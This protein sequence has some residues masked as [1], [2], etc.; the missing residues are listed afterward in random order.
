MTCDA[1]RTAVRNTLAR[2]RAQALL[3]SDPV[4]VRYLTGFESSNAFLLIATEGAA[5]FTDFRYRDAAEE[6]ARRQGLETVIITKGLARAVAGWCRAHGIR[7]AAFEDHHLTVASFRLLRTK[8]RGIAWLPAAVPV[9][10]IRAVKDAAE[11]RAI[12]RA[13]T[14]AEDAFR[15]IP[16]RAWVGLTELEAAEMLEERMRAA[17]RRHGWHADRAFSSIVAAGANASMPHHTPSAA[18]IRAGTLLKID[19]GARVD[20]YCSDITRT[21][22]LGRPD[23]RFKSIYATVLE[24]Q[25]AAIKAVKPG[26]R[27]KDVDAAARTVIARAGHGEC[28]GHGT[29]HGIG[30]QVHEG[31]A[32]NARSGDE[33]KPGMVFTIEPGIYVPGW[34]GIRVEDMVVVTRTGVRVLTRLAK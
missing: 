13:V 6:L 7:R 34:G 9:A 17:A 33:A 12:R 10:S 18:R 23:R 26:V 30:M 16:P 2:N 11:L 25:R 24:A 28:F 1:R 20:G 22:Y 21:L 32:V 4:N 15:S 27:L 14:V 8:A 5:L 3:V 29:G 19:W 31:I